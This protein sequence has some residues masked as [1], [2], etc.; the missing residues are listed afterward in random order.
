MKWLHIAAQRAGKLFSNLQVPNS[1][2]VLDANANRLAKNA[3]DGDA[4]KIALFNK[5]LILRATKQNLQP[6]DGEDDEERPTGS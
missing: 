1:R 5:D 3:F 6:E 4:K 2:G